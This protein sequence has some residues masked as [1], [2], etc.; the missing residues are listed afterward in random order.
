[1]EDGLEEGEAQVWPYQHFLAGSQQAHLLPFHGF[2]TL[3]EHRSA[4]TLFLP[5]RNA[6]FRGWQELS[7]SWALYPK[8][9]P[10]F[11]GECSTKHP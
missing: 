7:R 4:S 10:D 5:H 8:P 2:L 9:S 11:H 3:R 6:I 1:M